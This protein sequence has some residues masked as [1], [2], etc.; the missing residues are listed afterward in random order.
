M[1]PI[2]SEK[3]FP[4][5]ACKHTVHTKVM[6]SMYE[7]DL[8]MPLRLINNTFN[9]AEYHNNNPSYFYSFKHRNCMDS[10][11]ADIKMYKV[12]LYIYIY[13]QKVGL[14]TTTLAIIYNTDHYESNFSSK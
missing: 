9:L 2:S 4:C 7:S 10:I 3:Q 12:R 5:R 6:H 8:Q 11:T 13:T 1:Y 14:L